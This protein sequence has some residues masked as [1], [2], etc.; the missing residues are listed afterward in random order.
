[1]ILY[2]Y[3][4]KDQLGYVKIGRSKQVKARVSQLQTSNP[5][6]LEL[7]G[8][9]EGDKE[10]QLHL[11]FKASKVMNE[12]FILNDEIL[13]YIRDNC[14]P[15]MMA[16]ALNPP[17][18]PKPTIEPNRILIEPYQKRPAKTF[19]GTIIN[20]TISLCLEGKTWGR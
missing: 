7:I 15:G 2:T 14:S 3:F 12:W 1:M 8:A 16:L 18:P 11:R 6:K 13:T 4:I 9:L 5:T 17:R 10:E 20:R 19:H